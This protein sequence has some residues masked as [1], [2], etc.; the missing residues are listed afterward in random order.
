[1]EGKG[2]RERGEELMSERGE[3]GRAVLGERAVAAPVPLL[4]EMQR[5]AGEAAEGDFAGWGLKN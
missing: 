2:G 3:R 5:R 4:V 1:M